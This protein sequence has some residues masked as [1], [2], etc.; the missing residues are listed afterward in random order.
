[1]GWIWKVKVVVF[2][3]WICSFLSVDLIRAR[4]KESVVYESKP[5]ELVIYEGDLAYARDRI[6]INPANWVQVYLPHSV[7]ARTLRIIDEGKKIK[8]FY[9]TQKK[10]IKV[11]IKAPGLQNAQIVKWKSKTKKSRTA[12]LNYLLRSIGWSPVYTMDIL[13]DN[14]VNFR[15]NVAIFN[16]TLPLSNVKIKLVSGMVSKISKGSQSYNK[17]HSLIQRELVSYD[18]RPT[19][20]IKV[21]TVGS[22]YVN[23]YYIYDLGQIEFLE[24]GRNHILLLEMELE[25]R[26]EFVWFTSK[27]KKVDV[28]YKVKNSSDQPFAAGVVDVYQDGIY[29][30]SDM[31]DWTPSGSRGHI[32]IGGTADIQV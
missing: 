4:E 7:I 25:V 32:V 6:K 21:P 1:M 27:G 14:L 22:L 17:E 11:S 16:K 2:F 30:G 8:R 19:K 13:S 23:G 26:K 18:Y 12:V 31:I 9:F 29:L 5:E 10:S 3:I 28:V 15:Y 20:G 24:K